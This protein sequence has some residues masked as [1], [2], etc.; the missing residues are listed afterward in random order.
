MAQFYSSVPVN[1]NSV[2]VSQPAQYPDPET[3]A[4]KWNSVIINFT[5]YTCAFFVTHYYVF[6]A[7]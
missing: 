4:A 5:I 2:T 1:H 7:T 6:S 3:D